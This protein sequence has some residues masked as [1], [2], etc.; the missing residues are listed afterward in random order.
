MNRTTDTAPNMA[1]LEQLL[2]DVRDRAGID[3]AIAEAMR[4]AVKLC[5]TARTVRG[6]INMQLQGAL[7][8]LLTG[9]PDDAA[10]FIERAVSIQDHWTGKA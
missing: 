5:Q 4:E 10:R 6:G 7:A 3:P 9:H 1:T 8:S 2:S